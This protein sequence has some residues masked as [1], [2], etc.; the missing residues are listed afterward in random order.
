MTSD[1]GRVIEAEGGDA[2]GEKSEDVS[3]REGRIGAYR[4]TSSNVEER[5]GIK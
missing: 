5:L 2:I 1:Q 4:R 3:N